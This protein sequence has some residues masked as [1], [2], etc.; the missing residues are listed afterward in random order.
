[1][2]ASFRSPSPRP[3]LVGAT[4][5]STF[6][7][8]LRDQLSTARLRHIT[9]RESYLRSR[10][11]REPNNSVIG[12]HDHSATVTV[13]GNGNAYTVD[14]ATRSITRVTAGIP[15]AISSVLG[16]IPSQLAVDPQGNVYIA[17]SGSSTIIRLSLTAPATYTT[18]S[19][20]PRRQSSH[21]SH[22]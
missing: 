2:I 11:T 8:P 17:T 20:R 19:R 21:D 6:R 22:P 15:T 9:R 12:R 14:T 10:L 5:R 13:D 1:M 18:T 16:A 4:A 3:R 7:Q